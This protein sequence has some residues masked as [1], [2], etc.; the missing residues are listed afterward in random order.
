MSGAALEFVNIPVLLSY[1]LCASKGQGHVHPSGLLILCFWVTA[2]ATDCRTGNSFL[3]T[4][5]VTPSGYIV[6][7]G[8][9]V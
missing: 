5:F 3:F 9:I 4:V 8:D 1:W 7:K 6:G 2:V